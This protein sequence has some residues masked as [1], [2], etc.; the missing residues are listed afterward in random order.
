MKYTLYYLSILGLFVFLF[1]CNA[2][3]KIAT[4]DNTTITDTVDI[5]AE[6]IIVTPNDKKYRPERTKIHDLLHTRL[7]VSFDW[8]K[9]Q[10]HGLATLELKPYFYPQ[11]S[12][13][14][15]AKNFD[16]HRIGLI[17]NL[18]TIP[19]VYKY[20]NWQL[21]IELDK[22]YDREDKYLIFIDYTAKPNEREAG[23]SAAITSD[24]GLYFINPLGSDPDKPKQIWTQGETESNSFWFP[25]IDA[26]NERTTQEMFITVDDKFVT[27]SNGLLISSKSNNN[28]TRT[29]YWKMDL[30]H[31]PYLFMMAIGEYAVV[32]DEWEGMEVSYYVEPAYEEHAE[33]IFGNTPEML[34]FFSNLLDY[35]YP[36]PKY[37]Q[38]VVRDF[39]SGAMENTTASVFM[40]DLQATSREL[41]DFNWDG[42]IA[43]E[44][45]HQ[46][47]GNLLTCESWANLPLNEAFAN[48]SEYLWYEYKY[49]KDAAE[50]H[51]IQELE[52]YLQE[53]QE[54]QVDLIRY[55]YEDRE[56]MFDSHSY[57]KGGRILH[58]LRHSLGDKAF[59]AGLKRYVKENEFND[60]EVHDLRLAF[61]EATGKDLNWFFNQWFL[62]SG[63]PK[64]KVEAV[65]DSIAKDYIVKVWQLQDQETTPLYKLPVDLQ[66]FLRDKS[67]TYSVMLNEAY[68][69]FKFGYEQKPNLLLFDK[70]SQLVAEIIH[71]KTQEEIIF[72][73]K[74]ADEFSAKY[75]ALQKLTANPGKNYETLVNALQDEAWQIRELAFSGLNDYEGVHSANLEEK[76]V[77]LAHN[78]PK[79]SVRAD[80]LNLLS[81]F[82]FDKHKEVFI[83]SLQDSSYSV[84]GIALY[85]IAESS[86]E[87]K[88]KL[89]SQFEQEENINIV[90]PIANYY[91]QTQIDKFDW[92][93]QKIDNLSG[94]NLWYMLQFFGEFLM[95]SELPVQHKG[96]KILENAARN[97]QSYYVRLAAYQA[98]GLLD[99]IENVK[100]LRD[101]IR[102]NEKDSRLNEIYQSME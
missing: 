50:Y 92:F 6:P 25:T 47:I 61:E 3:K 102:S 1:R 85:T 97:S 86:M 78:E 34:T 100:D 8:Q 98:L 30:S 54:K 60:V 81:S 64:I 75:L 70:Q 19:L 88:E 53:A 9:Q 58:M 35:K 73:Y 87:D 80:A 41:I 37:S 39:V 27:L 74:N 95:N 43:H 90:F 22:T 56:A 7:H 68:H 77:S 20:D 65:Y 46:W 79:S 93:T 21:E 28:G 13:V 23:G 12:L 36:W 76:L 45:F 24:K 15:D 72:Q 52:K 18:D 33:A 16:I 66:I 5:I 26:P 83:K 59:F 99:K 94:T 91:S 51:N 84:L 69:E 67:R 89:L 40:E 31:A 57:A 2:G 49:G 82:S 55:Y 48:Y 14:L 63:H 44:L 38:V 71:D 42:I 32:R 62:A 4:A 101:D 11:D 29:D 17:E 96:A 10:L